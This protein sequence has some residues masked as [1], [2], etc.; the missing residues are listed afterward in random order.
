MMNGHKPLRHNSFR[1]I[2]QLD[3]ASR[4]TPRT[5]FKTVEGAKAPW[6][7]RFPSPSMLQPHR[8]GRAGAL[9]T[10]ASSRLVRPLIQTAHRLGGRS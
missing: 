10:S 4:E 7:V 3:P 8:F 6:R 2:A 9:P 5:V 1:Q